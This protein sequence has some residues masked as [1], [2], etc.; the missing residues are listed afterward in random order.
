VVASSS[1]PWTPLGLVPWT[2]PR[3]ASRPP[4]GMVLTV[5][6]SC[7]QTRMKYGRPHESASESRR[8]STQST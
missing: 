7:L 5:L 2:P 3:L 8:S 1:P 4:S 6:I